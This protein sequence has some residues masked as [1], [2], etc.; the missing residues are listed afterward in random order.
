MI[1]YRAI[2]GSY[3]FIG[4]LGRH[5]SLSPKTYPYGCKTPKRFRYWLYYGRVDRQCVDEKSTTEA[6][7]LW[8]HEKEITLL[9]G[10]FVNIFKIEEYKKPC[11]T[12][13]RTI[14]INFITQT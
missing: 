14:N 13:I 12:L 11:Q 2:C 5:W 4:R 6:N 7:K 10:S 3:P 1:I 9:P 8:P